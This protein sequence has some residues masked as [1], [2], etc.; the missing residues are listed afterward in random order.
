MGGVEK[1]VEVF[2]EHGVDPVTEVVRPGL[3][4]PEEGVEPRMTLGESDEGVD[5]VVQCC[6]EPLLAMV[7]VQDQPEPGEVPGGENVDIVCLSLK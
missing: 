7:A 3:G 5:E 1:P 4:S 2:G 6:A